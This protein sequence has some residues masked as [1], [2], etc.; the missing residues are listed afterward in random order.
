MGADKVIKRYRNNVENYENKRSHSDKWK[1]ENKG[2]ELLLPYVNN[3]LDVPVGTGRFYY[4][5]SQRNI[6]ATGVDS[7]PAMLKEAAK[8]GMADL[9]IGDIRNLEFKYKAFDASVCLRLFPWFKPEEVKHSL[10]ELSRVSN[11]IIVGIRTN[12][13]EAFCKNGS[14]WNHSY[15]EFLEWIGYI[16]YKIDDKYQCGNGGNAIYRLTPCE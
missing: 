10:K 9:R 13:V 15:T 16:G 8:K 12:D 14:L 7:S 4:L 11:I 5:Y 1:E 2:V 6:K 3:V